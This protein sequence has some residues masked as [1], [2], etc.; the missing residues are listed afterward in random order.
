M[1]IT[2][3]TG[4]YL[5]SSTGQRILLLFLYRYIQS[6]FRDA[7]RQ[8]VIGMLL[9]IL[10]NCIDTNLI[11]RSTTRCS[12]SRSISLPPLSLNEVG[13]KMNNPSDLLFSLIYLHGHQSENRYSLLILWQL[14]LVF[15]L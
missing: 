1:D 13:K 12:T 7:Y 15:F 9:Y 6:L 10:L 8:V 11:Y 2:L 3:L 5:T 14:A 4:K